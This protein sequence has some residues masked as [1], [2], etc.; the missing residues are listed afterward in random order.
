MYLLPY[1]NSRCQEVYD[2]MSS[3]LCNPCVVGLVALILLLNLGTRFCL[4]GVGCDAPGF[5]PGSLTLMIQ[6]NV[7]TLVKRRSTWA[8]TSKTSPTTP[9]DSLWSTLVNLWSNPSQKPLKHP[10]TLLCHLELL[11]CSPNFT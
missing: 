3:P 11:P 2:D 4:R 9:N 5:Q 8:I 10:L 1:L 6:S 7:L